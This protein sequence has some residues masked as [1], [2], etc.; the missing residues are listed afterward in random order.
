MKS[1]VK[2]VW[3]LLRFEH[4]LM[5]AAGV[6]AG[7]IVSAGF[8][9]SDRDAVLG[10]LTACLLQ[11]SA[12]ALNDYYD[13]EVDAANKRFDRPLVRGELKRS[14]ALLLFAILA[15]AG[16]AAAWLIS[17]EAF[18]LAFFITLLG[19]IYDVK[20]KEF[21]FAGNVY[22]AFSMAAPFIFGS[23]VATG[24]IEE[25]S[26]LL[27]FIAF[28]SG[29]GRE[30]M[31]GIEDVEGD[32]LR[33]VKTIAR[34]KGVNTAAKLSAVLFTT[35]VGLSVLPPLLIPEFF[36]VKYI[37]PV[38]ITDVLL[39]S[40]SYNLVRGG[41]KKEDIRLY[42]KRS[43]LALAIGLVAFMLGAL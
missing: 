39:L 5:Y 42:R 35:A 23:V 13:Y 31:K 21:G 38:L 1:K 19:Y 32:A 8:D 40:V 37:L 12:F 26:A 22:I 6:L 15:P 7:M 3:N 10:M 25:S 11:A 27:A 28:L 43:L 20:L 33:D 2:A 4:G 16:F 41:V 34:T 14:H 9:F 18:L 24:R 36:D 30:I 29:V 17:V